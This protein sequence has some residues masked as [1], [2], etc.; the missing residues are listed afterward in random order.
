MTGVQTCALPIFT[1]GPVLLE[2]FRRVLPTLGP[3]AVLSPDVGNAKTANMFADQLGLELA[4][5]EKRRS[6]ATDVKARNVIGDVNP[7][8]TNTVQ[9]NAGTGGGSSGTPQTRD[10]QSEK[11]GTDQPAV[12]TGQLTIVIKKP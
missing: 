9:N 3:A 2:H 12:R 1:A 8:T 5:I 10:A 4:I 6:G 7:T 11:P